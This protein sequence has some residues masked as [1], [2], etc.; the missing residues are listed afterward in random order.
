[1]KRAILLITC[2]IALLLSFTLTSCD[3]ESLYAPNGL[4]YKINDDGETCT[5]IGIGKCTDT[6]VHIPEQIKK[7]KVTAIGEEAF[8]APRNQESA[9]CENI[10]EFILPNGLTTI[11]KSAFLGCKALTSI[12]IPDTVLTIEACAF[13]ECTALT[14]ITLSESL[15]SISTQICAGCTSLQSIVIPASVKMIEESAFLQSGLLQVTLGSE[16]EEIKDFAFHSDIASPT[17]Y[18]SGTTVQWKSITFGSS[19]VFDFE[20]SFVKC[21]DSNFPI[22]LID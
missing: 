15:T 22:S 2:I 11:E 17:F 1:M 13:Q 3:D 5:I 10:T 19:F 18:Y 4:E 9:L 16:I 8:C 7:Y 21:S 20:N 12:V 6:V 14:S